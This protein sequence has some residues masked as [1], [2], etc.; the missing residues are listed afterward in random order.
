MQTAAPD[1]AAPDT[2]APDTAAPDTAAPDTAAPDTAAPDQRT[3]FFINADGKLA[4]RLSDKVK[5]LIDSYCDV[6]NGRAQR[7][8]GSD[9][10]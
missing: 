6:V 8:Y 5:W 9:S 7:P 4:Y 3:R 2:A 1:T 10:T